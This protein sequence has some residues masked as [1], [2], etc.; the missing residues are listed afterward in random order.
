MEKLGFILFHNLMIQKQREREKNGKT[1]RDDDT[2][3]K[4][5]RVMK[6]PAKK[7]DAIFSVI[8]TLSI[9][10]WPQPLV[11]PDVGEKSSSIYSKLLPKK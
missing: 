11:R 4:T 9:L 1:H 6:M 8:V 2:K 10:N 5:D 7:I 3:T